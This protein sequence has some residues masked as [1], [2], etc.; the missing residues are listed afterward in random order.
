MY[1]REKER[2]NQQLYRQKHIAENRKDYIS[3]IGMSQNII[4]VM[5]CY[6]LYVQCP[7]KYYPY[8]RNKKTARAT[9]EHPDSHVH[10]TRR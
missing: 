10:H 4:I 8:K 9:C 1:L 3:S 2:K 7:Q 6:Y 5:S